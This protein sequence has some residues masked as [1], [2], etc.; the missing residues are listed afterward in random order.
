MWQSLF[1]VGIAAV[2]LIIGHGW[3]VIAIQG[4][5]IERN[6]NPVLFGMV[7]AMAWLILIAGIALLFTGK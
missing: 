4:S 2:V 3:G 1:I 7:L 6:K 5:S